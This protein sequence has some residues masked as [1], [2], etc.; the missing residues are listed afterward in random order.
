MRG[1]EE[2]ISV[3]RSANVLVDKNHVHNTK[4]E[5]IDIK[6]GSR[7]VRVRN[8]YIHHVERQGLYA[9]AWD[10]HTFD[11]RFENNV[12]HDSMMGLAACTESG[13]LLQDVWFVNNLI[14]DCKGPGMILAKWGHESMRHDIR[15]VYFL[16]NTVVN[17]GNGGEKKDWGGGIL[18]ENDQATNVWVMNNLFSGSPQ[19]QMRL[20]HFD[21]APKNLTVKNNL[22]DGPSEKFGQGN[23][24]AKPIFINPGAK[25]FQL[26][27]KSPGIDKGTKTPWD[28]NTD[29]SG[30][31]RWNGR[32][33]DVGAFESGG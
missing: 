17:C 22:V 4:H 16:N 20:K 14:Y 31:P 24:Y 2:S 12:V 21:L 3:K 18:L 5:G 29:A 27:P 28:G 33:I 15:E 30:N 9:D 25:Q 19:D 11:I 32:A 7:H 6:E 23:V 1:G 13:G 10:S 26:A 8:N